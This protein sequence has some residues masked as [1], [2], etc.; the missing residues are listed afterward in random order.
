M[1]PF[2]LNGMEMYEITRLLL[3][4]REGQRIDPTQGQYPPLSAFILMC[5]SSW[6]KYEAL[7]ETIASHRSTSSSP[8]FLSSA[9]RSLEV[10]AFPRATCQQA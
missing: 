4:T 6:G 9:D 10:R 7:S 2:P 3:H 8:L 1:E 5:G